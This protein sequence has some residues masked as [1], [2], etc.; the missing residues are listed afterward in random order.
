M[1]LVKDAA[2]SPPNTNIKTA[3]KTRLDPVG[4]T[5]RS[6]CPDRPKPVARRRR[7]Y[8]SAARQRPFLGAIA[9]IQSSSH[10]QCLLRRHPS[11][12]P[13]TVSIHSSPVIARSAIIVSIGHHDDYPCINARSRSFTC[14]AIASFFLAEMSIPS[15]LI[16]SRRHSSIF[17]IH[18]S[19]H[20]SS[21]RLTASLHVVVPLHDVLRLRTACTAG[22][23]PPT[24]IRA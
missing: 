8:P 13:I 19:L 12:S 18:H 6:Y 22:A 16:G 14:C 24:T 9:A 23:H 15:T 2:P 3:P 21:R 11:L 17:S 20:W 10:R 1:F 7:K 4:M 5:T